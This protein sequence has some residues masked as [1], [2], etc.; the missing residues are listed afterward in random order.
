[1]ILDKYKN[2]KG[3]FALTFILVLFTLFQFWQSFIQYNLGQPNKPYTLVFIIIILLFLA[4]SIYISL[5]EK[6]ISISSFFLL[7]SITFGILM[8]I[9]FPPFQTPDDIVHFMRAYE[10]SEGKLSPAM[11]KKSYLPV[12]VDEFISIGGFEDLQYNADAKVNYLNYRSSMKLRIDRYN[13]REQKLTNASIYAPHQYIPQVIGIKI[14]K[15]LRLPIIGIYNLGRIFSLIFWILCIYAAIKLS[16]FGK[17]IILLI[18]LMPVSIQQVVSYSADT[19]LNASCI[20][21]TVYCFHLYTEKTKVSIK[22]KLFLAVLALSIML[23]K[24]VYAP[25]LLLM[26]VISSDS[27]K[28]SREK[29]RF[30]ITTIS[31]ALITYV[32]WLLVSSVGEGLAVK[33]ER[34]DPTA[35]LK[36]II[37][38]PLSYIIALNNTFVKNLR[39]YYDSLVGIMGWLDTPLPYYILISYQFL[40]VFFGITSAGK[41]TISTKCKYLLIFIVFSTGIAIVSALYI[42][43]T[44]VGHNIVQGVQGRYFLPVVLPVLLSLG[45]LISISDFKSKVDIRNLYMY[46]VFVIFTTI[47]TIIMRYYV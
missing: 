5:Y 25:M 19:V 10:I 12:A 8:T 18:G 9:I 30:L 31:T 6:E 3:L 32:L 47:N 35:Q 21:L 38:N 33:P 13:L 42:T 14:G 36:N 40:Y 4:L 44:P 16:P 45:K 15:L 26:L 43:W 23:S 29:K 20:L 37:H 24:F 1:M 17:K 34:V 28:S 11:G 2:R 27:F 46:L 7:S 41:Y 22:N 39:Y